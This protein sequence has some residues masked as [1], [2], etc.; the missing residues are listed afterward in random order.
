MKP[1]PATELRR[2]L[3]LG[4]R[5]RVKAGV[6]AKARGVVVECLTPDSSAASIT[7]ASRYG[8][9]LGISDPAHRDAS[10]PRHN[11]MD[12]A[13]HELVEL[14]QRRLDDEKRRAA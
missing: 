4:A 10:D 8:V 13:R 12:F 14:S 7:G 2:P 6:Y 1:H 5:V 11:V 3:R 9:V